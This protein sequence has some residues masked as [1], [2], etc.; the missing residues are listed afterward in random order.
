MLRTFIGIMATLL[1]IGTVYLR[2]HYVIDLVGGA[3]FFGLT[4]WT[5]QLFRAWWNSG[6]TT[7]EAD[8]GALS[9]ESGG[10]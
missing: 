7:P 9:E 6:S 4:L 1:I 5:G 2:Y 3:L 10:P 8:E